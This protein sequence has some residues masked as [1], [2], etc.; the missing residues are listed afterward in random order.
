M[1]PDVNERKNSLA[2]TVKCVGFCLRMVYQVS[3]LG[4]AQKAASGFQ[5]CLRRCL[6]NDGMAVARPMFATAKC[7]AP[8]GAPLGAIASASG[9]SKSFV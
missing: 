6:E 7:K 2:E 3:R 8:D 9:E 1:L 5:G 4:S